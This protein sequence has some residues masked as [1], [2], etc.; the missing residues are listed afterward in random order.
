MC[1]YANVFLLKLQ[2]CCCSKNINNSITGY[3]LYQKEKT[4]ELI[5]NIVIHKKS[6]R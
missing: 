4:N 5:V 2:G 3:C 6:L 1:W